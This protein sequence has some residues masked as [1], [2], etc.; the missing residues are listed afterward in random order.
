M[1]IMNDIIFAALRVAL[2]PKLPI[3]NSSDLKGSL[4][5]FVIMAKLLINLK[6]LVIPTFYLVVT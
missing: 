1:Y 2:E 6:L 5:L 3:K 4:S